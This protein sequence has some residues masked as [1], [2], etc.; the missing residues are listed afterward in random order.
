VCPLLTLSCPIHQDIDSAYLGKADLEANVE[1]LR[2]ETIFLQSL[3][4]Q[5]TE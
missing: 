3:Y 1:S 5:V 4:E 2:E